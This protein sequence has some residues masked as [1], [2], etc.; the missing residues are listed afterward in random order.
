[1]PMDGADRCGS[2]RT[3]LACAGMLAAVT[4]GGPA[5]AQDAQPGTASTPEAPAAASKPSRAA[6]R[7]ELKKYVSDALV[8]MALIDLRNQDNPAAEDYRIAGRLIEQAMALE[9]DDLELVR[10]RLEAAFNAEDQ[11]AVDRL[12]RR[13]LAVDPGDTV[14]QLALITSQISRVQSAG[15]RLALFERF[16]GKDGEKLDPSVRSRLALDAAMLMRETGDYAGFENRLK[17]A[18]KLDQT[19]KDAAALALAYFSQSAK[20]DLERFN[21]LTNLLLADPFDPATHEAIRDALVAAGAF[22]QAQKFAESADKLAPPGSSDEDRRARTMNTLVLQW[23]NEGGA[24]VLD[25][26]EK[27]LAAQREKAAKEIEKAKQA[28]EGLGMEI[29]SLPKPEDVR[30]Y[31][32]ADKVRALIADLLGE[33]DKLTAAMTDIGRSV[34]YK[35]A[36][37]MDRTKRDVLLSDEDALRQAAAMKSDLAM[38]RLLLGVDADKV[39]EDRKEMT[40]E[41]GFDPEQV[42]VIDAWLKLRNNDAAGAVSAFDELPE[43]EI[44]R[45]LGLA[46]VAELAGENAMASEYYRQVAVDYGGKPLGA[47]AIGRFRSIKGDPNAQLSDQSIAIAQA[48]DALPAWVDRMLGST[49]SFLRLSAKANRT[50]LNAMDRLVITLRIQNLSPVPLATGSDAPISTRMLVSGQFERGLKTYS[51][52]PPEIA[53][54]DRRLRLNPNEVLE[55]RIS[56][57]A[58]M[59]GWL[60]Q[61]A[62]Q[63]SVRGRWRVLQGFVA[64]GETVEIATNALP[65]ESESLIYSPIPETSLPA[66]EVVEAI[67]TCQADE[68]PALLIAARVLLVASS[69]QSP[70]ICSALA[71]RYAKG[72]RLERQAILTSIPPK[73]LATL[74]DAFDAAVKGEQ[75]PE[76]AALTLLTRAHDFADPVI[77]A[78]RAST[79]E[80]LREFA[81]WVASRASRGGT[82]IAQAWPKFS[83]AGVRVPHDTGEG[84]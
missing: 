7:I 58:G 54:V 28:Q 74:V 21:L 56:P 48:A 84:K 42:Q 65:A 59:S 51:G 34:E 49:R 79:S 9:P 44:M 16:L 29:S 67:K 73:S 72:T 36:N 75:D 17:L 40:P 61:D 10:R 66:E 64:A 23:L 4:I 38:M 24:T 39:V 6:T 46:A 30:L 11:E 14:A 83:D 18:L 43:T 1:M 26:L 69:D 8:R 33:R 12:N 57:E 20:D 62:A 47:W 2:V 70:A 71:E 13:I 50:T 53:L 60:L 45:E 15:E 25:S 35:S 27:D 80:S 5:L 68:L 77:A 76:L 52:L 3:L 22:K 31:M 37:L 41:N 81:G 19:N 32:P 78:A 63:G 55:V 82:L